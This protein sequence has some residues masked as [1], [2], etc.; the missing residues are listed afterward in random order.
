MPRDRDDYDDF[1]EEDHQRRRRRPTSRRRRED[2]YDD[3]YDDDFDDSPRPRRRRRRTSRSSNVG[4]IIGLVVGGFVLLSCG[5]VVLVAIGRVASQR[6]VTITNLKAERDVG[7]IAGALDAGV[8]VKFDAR[9]NGPSGEVTFVI[10]LSCSEGRWTREQKVHM[11]RNSF[12][13][14]SYP[15]HEPTLN[16][17]NFQTRVRAK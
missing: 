11:A 6:D 9:N 16:A 4:L 7:L 2:D 13:T 3:E 5:G 14:F 15:F 8:L 12:R 10:E 17:R 1:E